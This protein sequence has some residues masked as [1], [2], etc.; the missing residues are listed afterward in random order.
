MR[1]SLSSRCPRTSSLVTTAFAILGLVAAFR[2]ALGAAH[3][4]LA[5]GPVVEY[6]VPT[7]VSYPVS[8][9]A[10]PDGALWFSENYAN[11]IGRI[12]AGGVVTNEF[13]I[14]T[15][16]SQP[17]GMAAGPDGNICFTECNGNNIGVVLLTQPSTATSTATP[18]LVIV[19]LPA[20]FGAPPNYSPPSWWPLD[21][22]GAGW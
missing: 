14:P 4:A 15:A 8:I 3:G 6:P 7:V 20:F 22:R 10:G 5:N 9:T 19:Y 12:T 16:G 21:R 18:T 13:P 17:C 11:N 1:L 2:L